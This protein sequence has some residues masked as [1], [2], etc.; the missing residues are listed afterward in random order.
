MKELNFF[1]VVVVGCSLTQSFMLIT[2]YHFLLRFF[3]F[4]KFC[5]YSD[6]IERK[7]ILVPIAICFVESLWMLIFWWKRKHFM[8]LESYICMIH[9]FFLLYLHMHRIKSKHFTQFFCL[10]RPFSLQS[11]RLRR[12]RGAQGYSVTVYWLNMKGDYMYIIYEYEQSM[13]LSLI[14]I[15][16]NFDSFFFGTFHF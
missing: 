11:Y 1:V 12:T 9:F 14:Y 5:F 8:L 7:N 2:F 6:C 4:F 10:Y 3:T 15:H 16:F 13:H